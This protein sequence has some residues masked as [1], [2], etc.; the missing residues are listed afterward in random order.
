[1]LAEAE[2]RDAKQINRTTAV[3]PGVGSDPEMVDFE[4]LTNVREVLSNLDKE[5]RAKVLE[6]KLAVTS[7]VSEPTGDVTLD[8]QQTQP[9]VS[10]GSTEDD[11]D[12]SAAAI[13]YYDAPVIGGWVA[14]WNQE[15]EWGWDSNDELT[16]VDE[17]YYSEISTGGQIDQWKKTNSNVADESGGKG[18]ERY[19]L[20][21]TATYAMC[22]GVGPVQQCFNQTQVWVDMSV[23]AD[24]VYEIDT[25]G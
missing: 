10:A 12:I 5:T 20:Y 3:T 23:K 4:K 24:Q 22:F 15:I 11:F 21:T 18:D 2:K 25:S 8:S 13:I 17:R 7:E 1:M 19:R 16:F 14:K 6:N 9:A